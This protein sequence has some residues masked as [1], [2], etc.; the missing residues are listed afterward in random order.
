MAADSRGVWVGAPEDLYGRV[1]RIESGD[2]QVLIEASAENGIGLS[3]A[4]NANLGLSMGAPLSN[5]SAGELLDEQGNLII[6]GAPG[7]R[8]GSAMGVHDDGWIVG[9]NNRIRGADIALEPP[10]RPRSLVVFHD[11]IVAGLGQLRDGIWIGGDILH[12]SKEGS[13]AGTSMCVGDFDSDGEEELVVGSP[14]TN[15]VLVFDS[16]PQAGPLNEHARTFSGSGHFGWSV[17]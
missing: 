7:E 5:S 3:L 12:T 6:E 11:Q 14:G 10:G 8:L 4:W 16:I 1:D 9:G 15:E 13:L 17:A 2:R